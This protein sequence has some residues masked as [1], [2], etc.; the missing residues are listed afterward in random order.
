MIPDL[1][2][3]GLRAAV[4]KLHPK[5]IGP[6]GVNAVFAAM[7][8]A[9]LNYNARGSNGKVVSFRRTWPTA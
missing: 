1:D 9:G 7:M 3:S 5:W 8:E 6:E 2:L 4:V